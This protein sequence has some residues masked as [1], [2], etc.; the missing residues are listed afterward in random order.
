MAY[1]NNSH[2]SVEVEVEVEVEV[3]H[4]MMLHSP[5]IEVGV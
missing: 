4:G 5:P 1:K 2:D 3:D